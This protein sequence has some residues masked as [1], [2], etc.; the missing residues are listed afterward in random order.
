MKFLFWITLTALSACTQMNK[1]SE[2]QIVPIH[3]SNEQIKSCIDYQ[4]TTLDKAYRVVKKKTGSE[5]IFEDRPKDA[6]KFLANFDQTKGLVKPKSQLVQNILASCNPELIK[7]FDQEYKRLS[8]C[9]LL[10]S[11][12]NYFQSLAEGMRKYS[13]PIDLKLEAK[14]VALDYVA[15]FTEGNYPLLNRLVALSVLD[16]LSVNQVIN[17]DLHPEIKQLMQDSRNYVEGLRSKLN[18]EPK[19]TC[20]G[21]D[22]IRDELNYSKSVGEKLKEFLKRI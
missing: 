13:W 20:N 12:L 18:N 5:I 4:K 11:E 1:K 10:F 16:E 19:L 2:P 8:D 6:R 3:V 17:K 22:V 9:S 15:Y 21:L 7:Q 14:K